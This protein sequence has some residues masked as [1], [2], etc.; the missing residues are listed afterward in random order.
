[1]LQK[2]NWYGHKI[3]EIWSPAVLLC[4]FFQLNAVI[5]PGIITYLSAIKILKEWHSLHIKQ[6]HLL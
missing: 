2:T 1:M 4:F 5:P 6:K 3:D